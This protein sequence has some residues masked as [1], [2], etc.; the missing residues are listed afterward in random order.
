MR[1]SRRTFL[2]TVG[3]LAVGVLAACQTPPPPAST[4]AAKPRATAAAKPAAKPATKPA[5]AKPSATARPAQTGADGEAVTPRPTVASP[6]DGLKPPE[7]A[8]AA[9]QPRSPAGVPKRGGELRI[10]LSDSPTS[11]DPIHAD[12]PFPSGLY[13][14]LFAWRPDE[15]GT[16]GAQPQL[17]ASWALK[18]D[19][20]MVTLRD[21]VTFHD[22]SPLDAEAVAW[23]VTRMVQEPTSLA[24]AYLPQVDP[25]RPAQALD[26]LTVRVN[27]TRPSAAILTALSDGVS[28]TGIVSKKAV[29]EHGVDWLAQ[30]PV[31]SGPFK[32]AAFAPGRQLTV[33][34]SP[35]S[36][37]PGA[38]G[39]PLPYADRATYRFG[40]DGAAQ[41]AEIRAG[42]LDWAANLGAAEL[43]AARQ[44]P[45]VTVADAA[46]S[47]VRHHLLFNAERPP[48]KDNLK[49]RQAIQYAVD[50]ATLARSLG[51]GLGIPL[52]YELLPG[53]VGYDTAVPAYGF[54]LDRAKQLLAE[55]GVTLP[56]TI[57]LAV[58]NRAADQQQA[59]LLQTM[60]DKV[61]IRV[62]LDTLE[63]E[64]WI[65]KVRV[66]G[67]FEMATRR[68]RVLTDPVQELSRNWGEGA[69]AALHRAKVP[70]LAER[71]QRADTEADEKARHQL[72]AEAQTLL[73]ESA[74]TQSLWFA[75][76]NVLAH[77]RLRGASGSWGALRAAEWWVDG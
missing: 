28:A 61:G 49:L 2:A 66:Q 23:N 31:G 13:D 47:G 25:E 75:N 40:L 44:L 32:L 22:G 4:P 6:L 30:H 17:A 12:G 52:P 53:T 20:L 71:L 62:S 77:A 10:V 64:A 7:S 51:A 37:R 76:G 35:S 68:D 57:R 21:G 36:L 34:R 9:V 58:H 16:Y 24:R 5:A 56:L 18:P 38:D 19:A 48:F 42:A 41:L 33:E 1:A 46:L 3:S 65:Q 39:Q 50:R 15:K 67:D 54:D 27:L 63:R 73:H 29:D 74:W 55:S 72:L 59:G 11:L 14:S 45:D 60:L 69:G 43:T 26:R 8:R 70:G